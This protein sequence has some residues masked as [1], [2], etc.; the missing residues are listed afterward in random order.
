MTIQSLVEI[1]EKLTAA[2][3]E[4]LNLS[5]G[6]TQALIDNDYECVNNNVLKGSKLIRSITEL[7]RQ[8]NNAVHDY[9]ISRGYRP[10]PRITISDIIKIVFKANEK[11][12][13]M[14]CQKDLLDVVSALKRVNHHNQHLLQVSLSY[15]NETLDLLIASPDYE[16]VYQNPNVQGSGIQRYSTF[17]SKA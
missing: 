16:V 13:L 15:V 11:K 9:L 3:R 8:R 10:D 12:A 7:E 1:M 14:E 2:H 4:L 17:D 5:E 6:E